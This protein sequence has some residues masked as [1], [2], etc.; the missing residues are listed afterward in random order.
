[1]ATNNSANYSPTNHALQVGASNGGLTSLSVASTGKIL[2]GVT[3]ADPAFSTSTYPSTATGT[4]KILRADGTNWVAST[5]TYP[6]TAGTSGNLLTSNG[7]NWSSSAPASTAGTQI[8]INQ[9]TSNPSDAITY[10]MKNLSVWAT[11]LGSSAIYIPFACTLTNVYAKVTVAVTGTSENVAFY[12][13]VND[14]TDNAV[15]TT[16]QWTAA[17]NAVSAT[18]FGLSLSA[19]D[20]INLKVVTPTW[21]TNPTGAGFACALYFT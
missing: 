20:Y 14:T 9:G 7:T 21:V 11:G 6:D 5:A 12:I 2:Q 8:Q 3:G 13:R 16:W 4:G 10:Y 1:M 19:G 17:S 15:T 18:S